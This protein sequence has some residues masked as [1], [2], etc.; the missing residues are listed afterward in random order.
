[1]FPTEKC[2]GISNHDKYRVDPSCSN[3]CLPLE[4]HR[5]TL[6]RTRLILRIGQFPILYQ[7]LRSV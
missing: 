5:K 4:G 6:L 2:S 1:M 7:M 3:I